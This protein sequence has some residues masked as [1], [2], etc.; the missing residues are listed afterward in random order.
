[1]LQPAL[2][3]PPRHVGGPPPVR[4]LCQ[5]PWPACQT[6]EETQ[7]PHRAGS[8]CTGCHWEGKR[9]VGRIKNRA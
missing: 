8:S 1:M 4:E 2:Q 6:A 3:M 5:Q 7:R 9:L